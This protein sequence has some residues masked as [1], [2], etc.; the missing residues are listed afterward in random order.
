MSQR[1]AAA[2]L[3]IAVGTLARYEAGE[4]ATPVTV[5]RRMAA[6]YH[7]GVGEVLRSSGT[8]VVPLPPVPWTPGDLPEALTALR[9][10]AGLSKVA[11][12]RLVGRSGQAV[13]QWE[14]G[15]SRPTPATCRRMEAVFGLPAGRLPG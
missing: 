8:P 14:A 12:G 11:L 6:I 10:A 4:R 15:R 13:S 5:V 3:R 7:R 9:L 2:H 1:E